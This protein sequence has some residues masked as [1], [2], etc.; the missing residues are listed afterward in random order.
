[1]DVYTQAQMPAKR[2][3]QQKVVEM[4]RPEVRRNIEILGLHL[5]PVGTREF[6]VG[7]C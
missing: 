7:I 2:K 5:F 3:A 4:V 6:G 1:M